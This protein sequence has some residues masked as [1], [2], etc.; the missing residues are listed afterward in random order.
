MQLRKK[1]TPKQAYHQ[2][3]HLAAIAD[4]LQDAVRLS[5]WEIIVYVDNLLQ[6]APGIDGKAYRTPDSLKNLP[7]LIGF[8]KEAMACNLTELRSEIG[9]PMEKAPPIWKHLGKIG[10]YFSS[11]FSDDY[12]FHVAAKLFFK[13]TAKPKYRAQM[14]AGNLQHDGGSVFDPSFSPRHNTPS[15]HQQDMFVE[16]VGE[17][18]AEAK[19]INLA[20]KIE[21]WDFPI[22]GNI[23]RAN[24][25]VA[26]PFKCTSEVTVIVLKITYPQSGIVDG[27]DFDA[28]LTQLRDQ[29]GKDQQA[30]YKGKRSNGDMVLPVAPPDTLKR[31][32][33]LI[34]GGMK[35]KRTLFKGKIGHAITVN[36]SRAGG[37][38]AE[39]MLMF[40]NPI[41]GDAA[42]LGDLIAAYFVER[43]EGKM[44]VVNCN[45]FPDK[46]PE[47]GQIRADDAAKRG[48]LLRRLLLWGQ[49]YQ[50]FTVNASSG[51]RTFTTGD[52]PDEWKDPGQLVNRVR[53]PNHAVDQHATT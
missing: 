26:Y 9:T 36:W 16:L 13:L 34:F 35:S 5:D 2:K 8:V 37:H 42:E 47:T 51:F 29:Q 11:T 33:R 3:P 14:H 25:Y 50:F 22:N 30:K 41:M 20:A 40:E 38:S 19:R 53:K 39:I 45:H 18:Q 10:T 46:Y 7:V 21:E 49:K 27:G 4:A 15:R 31:H 28:R 1:I 12:D 44:A 32:L 43:A 23:L 17:I 24:A 6:W 52:I 48:H